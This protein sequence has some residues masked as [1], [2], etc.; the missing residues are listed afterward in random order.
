MDYDAGLSV[1]GVADPAGPDPEC[2]GQPWKKKEGK[3]CGI[4]FELAFLLPPLMWLHR[5]RRRMS[6]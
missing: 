3:G 2:V 1:N 4:G 6:A 5:R